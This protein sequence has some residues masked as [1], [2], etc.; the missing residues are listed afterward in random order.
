M[1][2]KLSKMYPQ[3]RQGRQG[4]ATANRERRAPRVLRSPVIAGSEPMYSCWR[5]PSGMPA[6]KPSNCY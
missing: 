4:Q 2:Y 3:A 1:Y 5:A 6:L